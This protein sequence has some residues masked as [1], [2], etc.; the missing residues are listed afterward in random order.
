[1]IVSDIEANGLLD[2][3][4]PRFH[5]GVTEDPFTG[6]V[7]EYRPDDVL[8][9]IKALEAEAAKPDGCIVFHN[10][11]RYD[12]P[13][14]DTIKRKLTGKRLNIPRKR[15]IDTLVLSRLIHTNLKDTDSGLLRR[16]ILPG[17]R[18]GSHSLEAWGYRLGE[19]KGEYKDDFKAKCLEDGTEYVDGMEWANFNE[20]M[21][22][23]C[24]QDVRVTVKL[25][26]HLM[27]DQYY[28]SAPQGIRAVRIEHD[29][30]WTLA[31]MERNGFPFNK[32]KAEQ[33]YMTLAAERSDLLIKLVKTFGSW[34]EPKGGNEPFL[35]PKT[36]KVLSKYP[37]VKTAKAGSPDYNADGKTK[38]KTLYVK[39]CQYTPVEHVTFQPTSR[40][41][42]IK[43]L[44]DAG[45]EPTEFTEKGAPIVDD[46]TLEG[47]LVDDPVKQECIALIQRYL[48]IQKRIGQL[49]EGD[50]AWLR[51]CETED[52]FIHGSINPNGAVTG[53]ATHSFPNMGQVPSCG[54]PFGPECRELFGAEWAKHIPGWHNVKQ[55]G[56]D[57]SGLELRCLGHFGAR[58]DKGAYV[59]QVLNGDVHWANA[60]AAGIAPAGLV[61]DKAN[62]E[63]DGF[64]DKA[65][66]FIYAFLYGAGDAKIGSIVGGGAAAGKELKKSFLE[67][68]PVIASLRESIEMSLIE[69]QTFNKV[70]RK[71]DIKWK[72]R[73]IKGLDGRKIHVRSA[74]SALNA[75]LQSAGAVICKAWVIEVERIL[76]EDHGLKHGWTIHNDDGTTT[77]GDFAF[78]AW[79]HDELQIAARTP[80]IGGLIIKVSQEAIRNV[81]ESFDFRCQLDTEGKMG[82]TWR[83]CH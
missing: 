6:E 80:E 62:K 27:Q 69:S 57:A 32:E 77:P 63:H 53:R 20:P 38:S 75:L 19:M 18:Y 72:R 44:K 34:Y 16:G 33:L 3:P 22:A 11:I 65:K 4:D 42:I 5:C 81:G 41:N 30:A 29:A 56:V 35:H 24:V 76:M 2:H 36:G 82:P 61:R 55:V 1:M 23:Y 17:K 47:V 79:V 46:E 15:V 45:W 13:A 64:R 39:G 49:A 9:Y 59:D 10:G 67:N 74:H 73:W 48:M 60:L 26:R 83:E 78:M 40:P 54:A 43:V 71:F 68:T 58:S 14:L 12:V 8:A 31:K 70:T 50:K 7:I 25:M 51:Y 21:M 66:T 28:F 52:G 37:M